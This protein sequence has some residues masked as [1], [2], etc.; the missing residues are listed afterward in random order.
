MSED[1]P[2]GK[3][4]MSPPEHSEEFFDAARDKRLLIQKCSDCGKYQFYPRQVCV[5][6]GSGAVE[7]AEAS[8]KGTVH[9]FTVIHQ[10]GMPGWRDEVPYVAAIID[11]DEGVRMTSVVVDCAPSDVTVG[12]SVETTYIEEGPYVLPRFRPTAQ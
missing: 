6:C 9:T 4:F 12:M 3:M 2:R 10:Q 7:W 1:R 11:L 8:G 5:H